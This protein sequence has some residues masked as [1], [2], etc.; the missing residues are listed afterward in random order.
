MDRKALRRHRRVNL[1]QSAALIVAIAGLLGLCGLIL[2]GVPGLVAT[3]VGAFILLA[4]A[5]K[6]PIGLI[7]W[8]MGARPIPAEDAPWLYR[9]L[10]ALAE[11]AGVASAPTVYFMRAP[12]MTAFTLGTQKEAAVVVSAA[13]LRGLDRR[14]LLAVLAHETAHIANNDMWIMTLADMAARITRTMSFVGLFVLLLSVPLILA[15]G[16]VMPWLV[17]PVLVLAPSVVALLQLALSRTREFNADL[18]AAEL[19]G[20][21]DSLAGALTRIESAERGFWA[22]IL[23]PRA[24]DLLPSWLRT[25]PHAEERIARLRALKP[26]AGR[27]P[28]PVEH[29]TGL[30]DYVVVNRRARGLR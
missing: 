1:L 10:D 26:P 21:P 15:N 4:L 6:A 25:H 9:A 7:L 19:T 22:Q 14:E 20:D 3:V 17:V 27:V 24:P 28:I 23:S 5:P 8:R 11:R 2:A 16:A 18:V 12:V 30:P 13:L 29:D